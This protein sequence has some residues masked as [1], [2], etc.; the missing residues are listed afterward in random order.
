MTGMGRHVA[1]I[2]GRARNL[3]EAARQAAGDRKWPVAVMVVLVALIAAG[4][5]AYAAAASYD[6][7]SGLAARYNVALPR[8]NP[9]GIDGGLA[10]VIILDLAVTWL[11]EPIWW[12]RS[13]VRLFAAGMVGA[14]AAAGWPQPVGIGLRIAAPV[15]FVIITEAGR[16]LLLRRK[17]AA[18]RAA[19][20]ASRAARRAARDRRRKDR[21]P[22]IRWALDPKGTFALWR[23]MRLWREPSYRAALNME[24]ERLAAVE[25]LSMRYAPCAWQGEAPA[26]LVWMLTSGVRM[27]EALARVA[28]L[29][30]TEDKV[31]ALRAELETA[32]SARSEAEAERDAL[33]RKL[34]GSAPRKRRGTPARNRKRKPGGT[35][36]PEPE[37][38]AAGTS[39]LEDMPMDLDTEGRILWLIAQGNSASRAGILAGA[40]DSY[41]RQVAR[42]AKAA[43]KDIVDGKE[44]QS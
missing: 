42:L 38:A 17:H 34:P 29:I 2:T 3:R 43:P 32:Q 15:L 10:G 39:G 24:L 44:D 41:G 25:K 13:A 1:K 20:A 6:T 30:E 36:T 22:R 4:L 40:S 33:T 7:V 37:A 28:D 27:P 21:I 9:L 12:L 14:N 8:L 11:A 19:K 16:T 23:R 35:G 31:A 26:D 18:E 5:A